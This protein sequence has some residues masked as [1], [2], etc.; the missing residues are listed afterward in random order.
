LLQPE[1]GPSRDLGGSYLPGGENARI[2]GGLARVS[3][4]RDAL[5]DEADCEAVVAQSLRTKLAETKME[6]E[7]KEGA[8]AQAIQMAKAAHAEILQWK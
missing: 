4:E 1:G 8:V 5:K 7:L 6:L 3:A 2:G